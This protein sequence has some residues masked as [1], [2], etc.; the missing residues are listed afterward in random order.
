LKGDG[1]VTVVPVIKGTGPIPIPVN[2]SAV[3]STGTVLLVCARVELPVGVTSHI[4]M[5]LSTPDFLL[6]NIDSTTIS[7]QEVQE[8]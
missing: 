3:L 1:V 6:A 8:A 7:L 2:E 4:Q 5:S